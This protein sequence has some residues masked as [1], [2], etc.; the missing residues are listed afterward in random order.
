MANRLAGNVIIIDSAAG[1]RLALADVSGGNQISKLY[2]NAIAVYQVDTTGSIMLTGANT[3]LDIF[4]KSDWQ[5][6][7]TDSMGKVFVNNPSWF[8]FGQ[9]QRVEDIKCPIVIAGTAFLYL[10]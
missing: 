1:N 6:L 9:L 8:S 5:S 2:V 3:S 4:F 7:T 10:A